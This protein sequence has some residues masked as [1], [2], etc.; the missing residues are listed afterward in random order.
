MVIILLMPLLL[1]LTI[2]LIGSGSDFQVEHLGPTHRPSHAPRQAALFKAAPLRVDREQR[3]AA[4][5]DEA[6]CRKS[7]NKETDVRV[8][9]ARLET[10]S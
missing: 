7:E 4:H 2:A 8:L 5:Y 6:L 9:C 1:R 10:K 3:G